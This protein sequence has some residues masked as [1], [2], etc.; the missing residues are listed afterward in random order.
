MPPPDDPTLFIIFLF[1]PV[2]LGNRYLPVLLQTKTAQEGQLVAIAT[3]QPADPVDVILGRAP[4][5]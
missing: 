3:R 2:V 1:A 5:W 4:G